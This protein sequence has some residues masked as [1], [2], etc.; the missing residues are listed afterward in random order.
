MVNVSV[1]MAVDNV[2]DDSDITAP[3]LWP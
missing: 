1:S 3:V 2:D